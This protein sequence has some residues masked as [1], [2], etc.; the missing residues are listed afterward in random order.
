MK[1]NEKKKQKKKKEKKKKK[2][3]DASML[4]DALPMETAAQNS[5]ASPPSA[6]GTASLKKKNVYS[7]SRLAQP[8]TRNFL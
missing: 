6:W 2:N 7:L 1:N 5:V 8:D 4:T 3:T